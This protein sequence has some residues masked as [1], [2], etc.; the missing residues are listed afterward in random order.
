MKN[1]YLFIFCVLLFSQN[2]VC[3][4]IL[5]VSGHAFSYQPKPDTANYSA[6]TLNITPG[7]RLNYQLADKNSG[8]AFSA[9][10]LASQLQSNTF[11]GA[12][13]GLRKLLWQKYRHSFTIGFGVNVF[14]S[15]DSMQTL[16]FSKPQFSVIS[17]SVFYKYHSP[18]RRNKKPWA[19][20]L[21]IEKNYT[22][23]YTMFL[24]YEKVLADFTRKG[25]CNCPTFK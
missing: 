21:S 20:S 8:F 19:L 13:L 15:E 23:A 18:K 2:A 25:A 3:Q 22:K 12:E 1:L 5:S 10:I 14:F 16:N 11:A 4:H 6:Q 7:F 17:P 9:A 24:G